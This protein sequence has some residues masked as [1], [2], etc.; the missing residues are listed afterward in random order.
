MSGYLQVV[1]GWGNA[2]AP[3]PVDTSPRSSFVPAPA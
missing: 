2:K 1:D 3:T